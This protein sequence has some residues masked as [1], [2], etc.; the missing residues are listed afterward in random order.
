MVLTYDAY[1]ETLESQKEKEED[2]MS[3]KKQM[4]TIIATL[5]S[6]DESNKNKVAGQLIQKRMYKSVD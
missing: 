5:E 2:L 4:Q 6:L 1:N 3:L